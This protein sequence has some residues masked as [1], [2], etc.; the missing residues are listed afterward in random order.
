MQVTSSPPSALALRLSDVR[1]GY[2]GKT[3]IDKLSLSEIA[4]GT[5]TA[6]VGPNGAGKSTLLR[7]V[8]GLVPAQG[9]IMLGDGDLLTMH[10]GE[11]ARLIG[12]M[13]QSVPAG[14]ALSVLETVI[15]ALK[16]TGGI[17]A[18]AAVEHKAVAVLQRL[19]LLPLALEP[20]DRLSG[21]QRQ[22]ASLA[23][24]I[25]REP[26]LLLLDEPTSA[27]DLR[28][29]FQLIQAVRRL[30]D[31]GRVVLV[32]LHD[33]ALAA[34]FADRIVV[35]D[36]GRLDGEGPPPQVVTPAMLA[37]VYAITARVERCSAGSVQIMTD[38]LKA[39]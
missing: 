2:R 14:V 19:S 29:Q 1:A 37:R 3:V 28:H 6:I 12:F 30:A 23:Q 17:E 7:A 15:A 24:A 4:P 20:L 5:I 10:S 13:P 27:L 31:E 9:R 33:L 8:A 38:G 34:R 21:G 25:A 18:Q 26:A 35:L 32:V 36:H 39:D 11:R 22:M 16:A